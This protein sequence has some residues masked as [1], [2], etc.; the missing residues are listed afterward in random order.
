MQAISGTQAAER[1]LSFLRQAQRGGG[2]WGIGA[3]GP[4]NAQSTAW[5]VQGIIAVGR[6][7]ASVVRGGASPLDYLAARQAPD[8]HYSY[9]SG[10]D[11]TP[12][13]V[14]AEV[15]VAAAEKSLPLAVP[16]REPQ[17]AQPKA[18]SPGSTQ[19]LPSAPVTTA[20]QLGAGSSGVGGTAGSA[21]VPPSTFEGGSGSPRERFAPSGP[22][23]PGVPAVPLPPGGGVSGGPAFPQT[24]TLA[25]QTI[26]PSDPP[27]PWPP[28]LI[29]LAATAA[30]IGA[31]WWLGRRRGW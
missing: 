10:S 23:A 5:A 24:G 13:W 14:T 3:S 20:P 29:G 25:S 30:A 31:T 8:G 18:S 2:G 28:I 11:Q 6:N 4:A 1:G 21:A 16:A 7:P 19:A 27:S 26:E 12:V 15:L 17:P 9:S 22:T